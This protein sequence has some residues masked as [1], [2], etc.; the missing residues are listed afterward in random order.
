MA[1]TKKEDDSQV[2]VVARNITSQFGSSSIRMPEVANP[3]FGLP[4][5][6]T[7][8]EGVAAPP[9]V[10]IMLVNLVI[11]EHYVA[12]RRQGSRYDKEYP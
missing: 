9:L 8:S 12:S 4:Q 11:Q 1:L 7:P 3:E 5:G 6:Y 10:R 2:V